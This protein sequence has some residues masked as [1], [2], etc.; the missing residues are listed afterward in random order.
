MALKTTLLRAG[1]AI[2]AMVLLTGGAAMA[3]T[4]DNPQPAAPEVQAAA[5]EV[6]NTEVKQ[7]VAANTQVNNIIL[8]LNAK[9]GSTQ[10]TAKASEI[11]TDYQ[12]KIQTA[13]ANEGMTPA[14][15]TEI[16]QLAQADQNLTDKIIAEMES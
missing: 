12:K 13:I 9:L 8:E 2:A 14:R 5:A 4:Q 15:F 1:S 6:S 7:F 10:D 16:V 11:Q 3:Q